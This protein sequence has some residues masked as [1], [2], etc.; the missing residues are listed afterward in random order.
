MPEWNLSPKQVFASSITSGR[1]CIQQTIGSDVLQSATNIMLIKKSKM[2]ELDTWEAIRMAFEYYKKDSITIGELSK[3][4]DKYGDEHPD[5]YT[6][7]CRD[8]IHYEH[9]CNRIWLEINHSGPD[10]IHRQK[11]IQCPCGTR[12]YKYPDVEKFEELK[13]KIEKWEAIS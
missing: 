10:V 6:Y 5:T 3:W 2:K 4:C 12:H 11:S 13:Q 8:D 7:I 1:A 9:G